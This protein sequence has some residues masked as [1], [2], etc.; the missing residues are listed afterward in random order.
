MAKTCGRFALANLFRPILI[1]CLLLLGTLYGARPAAAQATAAEDLSTPRR[2]MAVFVEATNRGDWDTAVQVLDV[3]AQASAERRRRAQ[4]LAEQL[5]YVLSRRLALDLDLFSDQINGDQADGADTEKVV[6]LPVQGRNV[7]VLLT[8]RENP[9]RWVF[10]SGTLTRVPE[11]YAQY[12]PGPLEE[13]MPARLRVE[14]FG[15]E[16]WQWLGL[17]LAIIIA[18]VAGRLGIGLLRLVTARVIARAKA[19]LDE[20]TVHEL[21]AP[22]QLLMALLIFA[23]LAR[24]LALPATASAACV[25]ILKAL[26]IFALCWLA[27]RIVALV[28]RSVELRAMTQELNTTQSR[29]SV[30]GVRTRVRVLHRVVSWI[31]IFGGAAL[32]LMQVEAVRAVGVSLLASAGVAGI[33]LGFAAQRSLATLLAGIQISISQPI[34]IGDEVV[35]EGEFG[36]IEEITLTYVVLKVWDERRLIVPITRFLEQPFQNWTKVSSDLHGTVMLYA[37]FSLPVEELRREVDRLLLH[38]KLWDGRT[39]VVH[40]TELREQALEARVMI[41]ASSAG[42]LFDLRCQV[43]EGLAAWLSNLEEGRHLPRK[44]NVALPPESGP[45]QP[46]GREVAPAK[47][48]GTQPSA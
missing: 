2:A 19:L 41:S 22:A 34:R 43:R 40:I 1:T 25:S 26:G 4:P 35:V 37:N 29:F 5:D 24:L 6:T 30:R 20:R 17:G 12:G 10:S 14:L 9:T 42:R 15:L 48:L 31:L 28:S 13:R 33:V 38:S 21:R 8:R 3:S 16:R 47:R 27:L 23:P 39:K 36:V 45:L 32:L 44:I 18:L 46:D 11:L 7:S